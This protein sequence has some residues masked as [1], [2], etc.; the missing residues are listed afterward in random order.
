M[1]SATTPD[2]SPPF[3]R[4]TGVSGLSDWL[5]EADSAA[6]PGQRVTVNLR[7]LTGL[8]LLVLRGEAGDKSFVA[9]ASSVLGDSLPV[10]PSTCSG[11][12]RQRLLW[13][14]P[15]EWWIL[16]E[17]DRKPEVLRRLGN[18][19]AETSMQVLDNSGSLCALEVSGLNHLTVLR[20]LTPFDVESM[21]VDACI[22]TAVPQATITIIR[23]D[24][25][26]VTLLFRR[27]YANW[28]SQL[29]KTA[30]RPYGLRVTV[31]ANPG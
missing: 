9:S 31:T 11:D 28:L 13:I 27:S 16:L 12:D 4:G 22:S 5:T 26:R 14:S 19:D 30:A 8:S 18:A 10:T 2:R 6:S 29:L 1:S 7:E 23:P 15:D 17:T 25:A 24:P 3:A 21:P 20:H